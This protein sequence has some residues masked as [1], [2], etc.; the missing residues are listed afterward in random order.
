MIDPELCL[1]GLAAK[2]PEEIVRALAA[3]LLAKGHVR[4]S[5]EKAALAREKRSPT[6]LPFPGVAVAL[7]HAEPEHVASPA[8]A[9]A[10][11]AAP[12]TF[13]QMG[14]PGTKLT[15]S[16]VVMPAFSA[17]E[18]AGAMLSSLIERLQD[19]ALRD[20]LVKATDPKTLAEALGGLA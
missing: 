17:K 10:T 7:P 8:I 3:K 6:G 1:V 4:E 19:D 16:L 5:F 9:I 13:R 15:V 12:V 18:Q 2:T 20:R 11:L 14:S